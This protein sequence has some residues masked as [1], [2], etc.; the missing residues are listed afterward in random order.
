M[1]PYSSDDFRKELAELVNFNQK[2]VNT[3]QDLVNN[4]G[5]GSCNY[6]YSYRNE[7]IVSQ[8]GYFDVPDVAYPTYYQYRLLVHE[9]VAAVQPITGVCDAGGGTITIEQDLA[10]I[11]TLTGV[12]GRAQQLQVEAVALP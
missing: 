5:T 2:F 11:A 9:A 12:I 4:G 6:F 1:H 10:I 7:H 8:A 3:L